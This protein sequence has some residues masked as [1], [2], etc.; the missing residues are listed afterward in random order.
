MSVLQCASYAE[1]VTIFGDL[2][3]LIETT[4]IIDFAFQVILRIDV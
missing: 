4:S 3:V 2:T 1:H